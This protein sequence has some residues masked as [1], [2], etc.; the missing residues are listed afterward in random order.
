LIGLFIR[1]KVQLD[2]WL[3][4]ARIIMFNINFEE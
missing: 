3:S 1:T 4:Q 2:S